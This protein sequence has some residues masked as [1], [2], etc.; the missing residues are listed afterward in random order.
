MAEEYDTK[1]KVNLGAFQS[2]LEASYASCHTEDLDTTK[3]FV[4]TF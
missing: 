1:C 2:Q 3:Q 4:C